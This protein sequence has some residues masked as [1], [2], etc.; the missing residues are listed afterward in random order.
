M[1]FFIL[2][3]RRVWV[4]RRNIPLPNTEFLIQ[5]L[6]PYGVTQL[7][8]Y[9]I[10]E[11]PEETNTKSS[12]Q[13]VSKLEKWEGPTVITLQLRALTLHNVNQGHI[14]PLYPHSMFVSV[15]G[16]HAQVWS[17]LRYPYPGP[18]EGKSIKRFDCGAWFIF[19]TAWKWLS[20]VLCKFSNFKITVEMTLIQSKK[21][22]ILLT[23]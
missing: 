21:F 5:P 9:D 3:W 8:N 2:S 15:N 22:I 1:N 20:L 11:F 6:S 10:I 14:S 12:N 18:L 16:C 7:L 19:M 4:K 13:R 23:L 17:V